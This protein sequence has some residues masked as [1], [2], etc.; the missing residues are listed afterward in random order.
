MST[1]RNNP[2]VTRAALDE[3]PPNMVGQLIDGELYVH[4]RPRPRHALAN[5][6]LGGILDFVF[7][8]GA[9]GPGG[10]H[11]LMEP[12]IEL[13]A[14]PEIVP[15]LAGWRRER[16]PEIDPDN[17]IRLVPDWACEILSPSN[18]RMDHTIKKPFWARAGL[19]WLWFL[20]PSWRTLTVFK[21]VNG[22][23]TDHQL[24]AD[25]GRVRA[26]PFEAFELDL[27]LLWT[28]EKKPV[29]ATAKRGKKTARKK[30]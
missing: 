22:K 16:V 14:A 7:G 20:D 17:P 10:W 1:A 5:L 11:I 27:D 23:W 18:A 29:A 8:Y 4:P 3:V 9:G 25:S 6:R 19:P 24:F 30:R 28:P 26:E 15:D 21:L 13:P 12:G 2:P